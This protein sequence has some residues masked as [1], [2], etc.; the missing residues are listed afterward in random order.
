MGRFYCENLVWVLYRIV[1]SILL[2]K[3]RTD[4]LIGHPY[5]FESYFVIKDLD[6]SEN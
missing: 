3:I 2:K 6:R 4:R 5:F 1:N